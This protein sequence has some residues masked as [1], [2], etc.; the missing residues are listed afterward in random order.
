MSTYDT[1]SNI[2]TCSKAPCKNHECI[3]SVCED[4]RCKNIKCVRE[5]NERSNIYYNAYNN[6]TKK[7]GNT[8]CRGNLCL[9]KLCTEWLRGNCQNSPSKCIYEHILPKEI[10][11]IGYLGIG[12]EC[13]TTLVKFLILISLRNNGFRERYPRKTGPHGMGRATSFGEG[14]FLYNTYIEWE[15]FC[16]N[17]WIL[18]LTLYKNN[19]IDI[20]VT[21]IEIIVTYNISHIPALIKLLHLIAKDSLNNSTRYEKYN[22]QAYIIIMRKICNPSFFKES[23]NYNK[24]VNCLFNIEDRYLNNVLTVKDINRMLNSDMLTVFTLDSLVNTHT[25]YKTILK[26]S[27]YGILTLYNTYIKLSPTSLEETTNTLKPF[28]ADQYIIL[29]LDPTDAKQRQEFLHIL[30]RIV[31]NLD[32]QDV[33]ILCQL[34]DNNYKLMTQY[35]HIVTDILFNIENVTTN[36]FN[37]FLQSIISKKPSWRKL[38]SYVNKSKQLLADHAS[39]EL[40]YLADMPY[41]F[42]KRYIAKEPWFL[43]STHPTLLQNNIIITNEELEP[44]VS[45]LNNTHL[46]KE[47]IEDK[48]AIPEDRYILVRPET[49]DDSVTSYAIY[50]KMAL[51]VTYDIHHICNDVTNMIVQY[52]E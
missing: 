12:E 35:P 21:T 39:C 22:D 16:L 7:R 48:K 27:Y 45:N 17:P 37:K 46:W 24:F 31:N 18:K 3:N 29:H 5:S 47:L 11:D 26:K 28:N 44:Y 14:Y 30:S 10:T 41:G 1:K 19:V 34:L 52:L 43:F 6:Y 23:D 49:V 4:P 51:E 8:K 40:L 25:L 36:T 33:E 13:F 32:K 42:F 9:N 50:Y 20:I 15:K 38:L 2:Y